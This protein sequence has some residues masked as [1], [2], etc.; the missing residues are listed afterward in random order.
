MAPVTRGI[1]DAEEYGFVFRLRFLKRLVSPW[2]PIH[3]IMRVLLKVR[4]GL[5]NEPISVRC[6]H[7]SRLTQ[8]HQSGNEAAARGFTTLYFFPRIDQ[9]S[10]QCKIDR[11]GSRFKNADLQTA[12]G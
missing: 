3:G 5:V 12:L 1:A 11:R 9:I 7:D 10:E 2:I 6:V 8:S 4:T